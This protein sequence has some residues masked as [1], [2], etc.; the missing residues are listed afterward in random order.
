LLAD[1][2]LQQFGSERIRVWAPNLKSTIV[3]AHRKLCTDNDCPSGYLT[4]GEGCWHNFNARWAEEMRQAGGLDIVFADC[5][6]GFENG[7]G[8]LIGDLVER[9]V[10]R[11]RPD[12]RDPRVCRILFAVSDR[13]D[14]SLGW[15]AAES[16]NEIMFVLPGFFDKPTCPY[17]G[18]VVSKIRMFFFVCIQKHRVPNGIRTHDALLSSGNWRTSL[19]TV[20]Q[21]IQSTRGICAALTAQLRRPCTV[22]VPDTECVTCD[23]TD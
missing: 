22:Q 1:D 3:A 19:G 5:F 10:L 8:A 18:R 12:V 20:T 4:A 7:S 11:R 15:S 14:R 9:Q 21:W 23:H 16:V 13:Y 2:L 6:R 17:T